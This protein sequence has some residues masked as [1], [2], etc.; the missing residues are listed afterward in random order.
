MSSKGQAHGR[1][2][3]VCALALLW[4]ISSAQSF[5]FAQDR[6]LAILNAGVQS[7]EDG[8]A[9]SG[10]YQFLPGDFV[11]FSFEI[12]GFQVQTN[13][14]TEA[15][16]IALSYEVT[17]E[18]SKGVP[19]TKAEAGEI[20][21]PMHPEDKNWIPKR[22][23]SFLI[24]SFIGAGTF[25]IHVVAND[26]LSHKTVSSDSPFTIGGTSVEPADRI[27]VQHFSFLRQEDGGEPL[28]IAAYIPGDIVY[29]SFDATNFEL[30]AGNHFHIGYG[31]AVVGPDGKPFLTEPNA[32][33][34]E[35]ASYYPAQ[36]LPCR[37]NILTKKT[38][39][40]GA[41]IVILTVTDMVA[42]KSIEVRETFTLE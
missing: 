31:V 4:L 33:Q 30:G 19:L 5:C 25:K 26:L 34:L 12:A 18:D 3:A 35:D 37:I 39:E 41:Y 36:F 6:Q 24:P 13:E 16:S 10:N 29:I 17:M 8:P 2:P 20:K 22:R 42:K 27:S 23:T 28:A 15:R 14:E 32:A 21:V 9:A 1:P 11:Y 40:R 38:S 7:Y